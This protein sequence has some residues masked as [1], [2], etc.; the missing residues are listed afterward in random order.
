LDREDLERKIHERVKRYAGERENHT[1][2][3]DSLPDSPVF[4][5]EIIADRDSDSAE[6]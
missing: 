5:P 4:S 1:R 2:Q 3:K 6:E